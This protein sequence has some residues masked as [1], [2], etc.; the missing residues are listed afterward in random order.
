MFSPSPVGFLGKGGEGRS[1]RSVSPASFCCVSSWGVLFQLIQKN[2]GASWSAARELLFW[3][4]VLEWRVLIQ[5]LGVHWS[6]SF[7]LETK[8]SHIFLIKKNYKKQESGISCMNVCFFKQRVL[9][10]PTDPV[11]GVGEM[12]WELYVRVATWLFGEQDHYSAIVFNSSI[13]LLK[14]S[15]Q[16]GQKS[17]C[18]GIQNVIHP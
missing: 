1:W 18:R 12:T 14:E 11:L 16:K 10:S 8:H 2:S 4:V 13:A 7:S 17:L 3:V 5:H 15:C 6:F 9:V